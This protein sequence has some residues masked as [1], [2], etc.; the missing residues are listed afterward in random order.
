[1]TP[2][3]LF[4]TNLG[5]IDRIVRDTAR[6]HRLAPPEAEELNGA[7][8]LRLIEN[9]YEVFRKYQGRCTLRTYLTVVI[10]RIFLDTR[11]AAW[12][13][14]RPSATALRLGPVAVKLEALVSRNRMTAAEAIETLR[15][16]HG[17]TESA[18]ALDALLI[19]LP[20]RMPRR[21]LSEESLDDVAA[22]GTE[23][24]D[25]V[26]S[27]EN[28]AA[29]RR[30]GA[31]LTAALRELAAQDRLL[32][33]LRFFDGLTVAQISRAM[34]IEQKPLYRR[35]QNLLAQ[36]GHA[37]RAQGVEPSSVRTFLGAADVDVEIGGWDQVENPSAR[38]SALGKSSAESRS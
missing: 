35:L 13:K 9:S 5:L 8:R 34:R 11:N 24:G 21:F 37:L 31:A 14:W 20:Q 26:G 7:V 16:S 29:A 32:I 18:A 25:S 6:R 22:P 19:Q 17:V 33:R 1:M 4:L 15:T 28:A 27:S 12:G 23:S 30:T 3:Q 10:Q 2:E 36:L 38:P